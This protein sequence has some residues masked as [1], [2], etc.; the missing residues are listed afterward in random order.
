MKSYFSVYMIHPLNLSRQYLEE[1]VIHTS[2]IVCS[3]LGILFSISR[4]Y[5]FIKALK[6]ITLCTLLSKITVSTAISVVVLVLRP[7]HKFFRLP[8]S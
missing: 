8:R 7:A 1:S 5:I 3:D 4:V 6:F 2:Q